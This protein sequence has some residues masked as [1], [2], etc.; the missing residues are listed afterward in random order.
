MRSTLARTDDGNGVD[1]TVAIIFVAVVAK[2]VD[3]AL[4]ELISVRD[5]SSLPATTRQA[6]KASTC[7]SLAKQRLGRISICEFD[8][9]KTKILESSRTD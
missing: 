2:D 7:A 4:K 6:R 8:G 5:A 3:K 9:Q 1:E